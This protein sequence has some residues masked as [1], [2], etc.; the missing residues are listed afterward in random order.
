MIVNVFVSLTLR[1]L[2]TITSPFCAVIVPEI[3]RLYKDFPFASRV[4]LV[5]FMTIVELPCV[6]VVAPRLTLP[7]NVWVV[8][9]M[10]IFPPPEVVKL[11]IVLPLLVSVPVPFIVS[12]PLLWVKVPL[13]VKLP[14]TLKV[15]LLVAWRILVVPIVTA[16]VTVKVVG[17]VVS[18]SSVVAAAPAVV[19]V[20]VDDKV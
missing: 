6:K 15:P 16:P 17:S 20:R 9:A 8:V 1:I 4:L 14:A 18:I 11:F 7:A 13:F 2:A 10:V 19:I 5:P 12:V 3:V